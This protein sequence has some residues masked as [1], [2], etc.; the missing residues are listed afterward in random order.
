[1]NRQR[2]FTTPFDYTSSERAQQSPFV[3]ST[4]DT[5]A[6]L[7][8]SYHTYYAEAV[9]LTTI[10]LSNPHL[11]HLTPEEQKNQIANLLYSTVLQSE[12]A[13]PPGVINERQRLDMVNWIDIDPKDDAT[14]TLFAGP[15]TNRN[16]ALHLFPLSDPTLDTTTLLAAT[17]SSL[18]SSPH[19]LVRALF[20]LGLITTHPT[21]AHPTSPRSNVESYPRGHHY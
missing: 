7:W 8:N 1:M 12:M 13:T 2:L 3:T 10:I 6:E 15:F 18:Q 11:T 19:T 14:K 9:Y 20:E 16:I 21:S 17:Q 4:G 5:P